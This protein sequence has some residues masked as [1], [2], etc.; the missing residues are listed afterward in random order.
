[1]WG[2]I[3][4]IL[5]A[6]KYL[7][8]HYDNVEI[9]FLILRKRKEEIFKNNHEL[10]TLTADVSSRECLDLSYFLPRWIASVSNILNWFEKKIPNI[11]FRKIHSLWFRLNWE[12][13]GKGPF[14][15]WVDMIK[16]DIGLMD[17]H[18]NAL[19]NELKKSG[20]RV[21]FFLTSPSLAFSPDVWIDRQKLSLIYT[22]AY[23]DFFLADTKWAGD[24][25][26]S[27]VQKKPVFLVGCPKFDSSW[28]NYLKGKSISYSEDVQSPDLKNI[29]ILLKNESSQIFKHIDFRES[30]SEIINACLKTK[31]VRLTLK[32]HPRQDIPLLKE[33]IGQ[34]PD[35]DITVSNKPS[36]IL[37]DNADLII[38]FPNGVIL[39]ALISGRP[40]IEYFDY[41]RLNRIIKDKFGKIP[42][43]TFGGM[44]YLNKNGSLTS[45]FRGFRLVFEADK[46]EE[47]ELLIMKLI[48]GDVICEVK[49]IRN[50]FPDNASKRAAE[51][52]L[53]IAHYS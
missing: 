7:R 12:I 36:F 31:N 25:F 48:N 35:A 10:E 44:G 47:L 14:R 22:D 4:W 49:D 15:K 29:L 43:G 38:A 24:F 17:S 21:G 52:L 27:V 16:P 30:L 50:I 18:K 53:T 37:I 46:Q 5:P 41:I 23:Y 51:A 8:D 9:I 13:F 42:M 39:D 2:S 33:I 1:M 3:E 32:P 6:C 11:F 34:Y 28:I 40:V 20:I 26:K 19:F 45:V